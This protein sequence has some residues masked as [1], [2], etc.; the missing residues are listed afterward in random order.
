MNQKLK[1]NCLPCIDHHKLSILKTQGNVGQLQRL[2]ESL[3]SL[4]PYKTHTTLGLTLTRSNQS[5]SLG[6]NYSLTYCGNLIHSHSNKL[7]FNQANISP[8]IHK[9]KRQW[10]LTRVLI[11]DDTVKKHGIIPCSSNTISYKLQ[12]IFKSKVSWSKN[13]YGP[14]HSP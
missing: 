7:Q 3:L 1:D 5:V 4:Q 14:V 8:S 9:R 12:F 10:I 11:D 2:E 13:N 6:P